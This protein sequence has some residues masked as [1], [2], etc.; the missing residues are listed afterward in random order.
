MFPLSQKYDMLSS[1]VLAIIG[2][3]H[4]KFSAASKK[5]TNLYFVSEMQ[6]GEVGSCVVF[7]KPTAT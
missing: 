3:H 2:C 6:G 4:E 7:K 1:D 5:L